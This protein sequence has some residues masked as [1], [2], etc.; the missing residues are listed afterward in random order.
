[1]TEPGHGEPLASE[2]LARRGVAARVE[3]LDRDDSFGREVTRLEDRAHGA[4]PEG[5]LD[6][7]A[8]DDLAWLHAGL[9]DPVALLEAGDDPVARVLEAELGREAAGLG[10]AS[11]VD[12]SAREGALEGFLEQELARI[13][14]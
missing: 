12:F 10:E 8:G 4:G 14:A 5:R 11:L 1:V 2:A 7:I 9:R 6:S 13:L 3:G